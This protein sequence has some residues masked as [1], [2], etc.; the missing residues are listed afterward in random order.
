MQTA[1]LETPES[2]TA[3]GLPAFKHYTPKPGHPDWAKLAAEARVIAAEL[4]PGLA[5]PEPAGRR[6]RRRLTAFRTTGKNFRENRRRAKAG[7][8]D[9][10]PLYFIWTTTRA[11][12]FTCT[13]CD[14]HQGQKYP[15]LPNRGVLDTVRGK[16]LLEV[17]RTRTPSVYFAGGEP[18]SRADLPALTRHARDLSYYP[19]IINTNG[20]LIE[21]NLRK[22][23]WSTWLADTDIV[24]V[25]LDTLDLA[26]AAKMW[27]Y[28]KPLDVYRNLLILRELAGEMGVK[29]MVNV[30][31]QPG[32]V[33]EAR[34]VLDFA[35]DFGLWFCP[36]PQNEGPRVG[37]IHQDP[38]YAALVET[39]LAR[40]KAGYRITGS[41]RMNR[42]LLRSEPLDCRN[43]LKPHVDF[44]G[45]VA[46]PC[47]ACVNVKPEYIDV[48][49]YDDV[50]ALYA[51]ATKIISPTGFAGPARNQCGASCNWAQ[52]YSTDAYAHGLRH[53]TALLGDL[54]EFL[55][56]R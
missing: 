54:S 8:E 14:D 17:M 26:S 4:R 42:R 38:A 3:A 18:T 36:V 25:S 48:L 33:D 43:T 34:D 22:P 23:A 29:L 24:I 44:D 49:A 39:I 31:I 46:W 40:K 27:V 1:I 41:P 19:I 28:E 30:V 32:H 9:L 13:Y 5:R 7:R 21:R 55:Q 51:D 20:S 16:R 15:E 35:N 47:K 6:L 2:A 56:A 11:C 53:P 50:D 10:L 12:N 45:R 37:A 52:N